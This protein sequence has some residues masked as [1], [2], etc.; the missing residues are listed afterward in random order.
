MINLFFVTT[1]IAVVVLFAFY[2]LVSLNEES[3]LVKPTIEKMVFFRDFLFLTF[4]PTVLFLYKDA[5]KENYTL[6]L[7]Q[8]DK[9]IYMALVASCVFILVFFI[10]YKVIEKPLGVTI[11]RVKINLSEKKMQNSLL[12]LLLTVGLAYVLY[13]YKIEAGLFSLLSGKNTSELGLLRFSLKNSQDAGTLY[14]LATTSWVPGFGYLSYYL[15]LVSERK[16]SIKQKVIVVG[17][18]F[19]GAI[20]SISFLM[21]SELVFFGLG[22]LGVYIYCG[23]R[24]SKSTLLTLFSISIVIVAVFYLLIYQDKVT[25]GGYIKSILIHRIGMQ[26]VGN[27]MAFQ[28]F[29]HANY[30]GLS[31][32]S[33][34]L[35][36]LT[37]QEFQSP[38]WLIK[39][40][41]NPETADISGSLSSFVTGEAYGL[42][43]WVGV[44]ISGFIVALWYSFFSAT[45]KSFLLAVIFVPLYA[46]FYG[47][48]NVASSF[49]AFMWPVGKILGVLPFMIL[50]FLCVKRR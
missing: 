16:K 43:G 30:L 36:A 23:K 10:T 7:L 24:T 26:S 14:K 49:F 33:N 34:S 19:V 8:S 35:A 21:K 47:H 38:Y 17:W 13:S 50:A 12:Y 28:Y 4:I 41:Y 9:Y 40:I 27:I 37:D 22:Y 45:R 46:S 3:F 31:G 15:Y 48:I 25:D 44:L 29:E 5:Y 6:A 39:K 18:F 42:F 2:K 11:S 32:I 20:A 1:I